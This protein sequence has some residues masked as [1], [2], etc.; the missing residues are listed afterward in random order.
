MMMLAI[1]QFILGHLDLL[2]T[3]EMIDRCLRSYCQM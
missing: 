3:I 1:R 2:E